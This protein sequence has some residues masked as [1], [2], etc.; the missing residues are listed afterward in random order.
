MPVRKRPEVQALLRPERVTD[1]PHDATVQSCRAA[2]AVIVSPP[3][4]LLVMTDQQ[5]YDSLAAYGFSGGHTPNL[6]HL[7]A[8][9]AVFER[10]Y[11]TS[12]ICT[13]SRAS[14]MTGHHLPGHGVF[15]IYD[16][17]PDDQVLFPERLRDRG[18]Q[19][20]LVGK[21]HASSLHEEALRRHPH[22]GFDTYDW[23]IEGCVYMDS[24]Y[25]AYARW[26]QV[27]APDF[28]RKLAR[29]G[30]EAVHHPAE[31]HMAT[32][33]ADRAIE[34]LEGRDPSRPFF[35]M[36]SLFDP[37]DPYDGYPVEAAEK[38]DLSAMP[39]PVE[40]GARSTTEPVAIGRERYDGYLGMASS[41][42]P[43]DL[44]ALRRDYHACIAF[45]DEQVGRVLDRVD[46]LGLR[47]ETV[48]L[49]CSDHGDMLGDHGLL[50][51]GAF[52]YE[53]G[54]RVPL[55][56]R[57]PGRVPRG[58]RVSGPVQLNDVAATILDVA[59][60]PAPQ[61]Q[62]WMTDS[63]SLL[64]AAIGA[65]ERPRDAVVCAYRNSGVSS[66]GPWEPPI[67][68]TM[69]CDGQSKLNLYH[70]GAGPQGR[71]G[72]QL[73]DLEHDPDEVHDLATDP[74]EQTL[75]LL[76][77]LLEWEAVHERRLGTRA[78]RH[79]APAGHRSQNA[80]KPRD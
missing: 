42:S 32:W 55:L 76:Q 46:A 52:F 77:R 49:F 72:F 70:D 28:R 15:G 26:L 67:H 8:E 73:F 17:L 64:P 3:N 63:R 69:L 12:P 7:A 9:G 71:T 24:P 21:L 1:A 29:E 47:D 5:R 59:G 14:L 16:V 40:G 6:D 62:A 65:E 61:R 34:L 58:R 48:V 37:H 20:A 41:M 39:D 2:E 30:R 44:R 50:G 78:G 54:V 23:C 10:C 80:L 11:P 74:S 68:A 53:A 75:A 51:K 36:M 4:I 66:D 27:V 35:I 57:W 43:S 56:L 38:I 45:V 22:D 19:T 79:L 13:P 31:L 60:V 33:A 18:Y 25:Q